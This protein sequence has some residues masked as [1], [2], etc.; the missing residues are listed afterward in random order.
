LPRADKMVAPHFS[1]LWADA[2][3]RTSVRDERGH[4]VKLT[5]VAGRYGEL[6]P[7]PPP[8]SSWA[9]RAESDLAIWTLELAPHARFELPPAKA[10]THRTLYFFRGASLS[11]GE[12]AVP[13]GHLVELRPEHAVTL[14]NGPEVSELL[15]LQGRPIGEPVAKH[16]PFVMN[17]QEEIRQAYQDY[18][19]T[20]FG[21]WPWPASDP[22]HPREQQRFAKR[23]DGKI[24]RP[25]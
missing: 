15:M 13:P 11:L 20:Q 18:R 12:R 19:A 24:E 14:R 17:T 5:L 16:G 10:G 2:I 1:M 3:P 9:S 8:P 21:G 25:T 6:V 23:P 4:E 22:V 7:P